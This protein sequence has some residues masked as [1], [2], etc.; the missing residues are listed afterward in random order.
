MLD[1][2]VVIYCICDEVAKS[3]NLVDDSQCKM[4][5]AEIMCFA[6]LS[7]TMF[8]CD[9]KRTRLLVRHYN[10][11][12]MLLSHSRVVR[13]IHLVPEAAWL[14]AFSALRLFVRDP[15]K[16]VFI[17]DSFP[18]K[19]YENHKSF[20]ARIFVGKEF[21]G[22]SASRKQYFFGIKV[23]MVVDQD[24]VPI[25]VSFHPGSVADITALKGLPL[26]LPPGSIL[27]GDRAYTNYDFEDDLLEFEGIR[28]VAKR[29]RNLRRQHPPESD[30]LLNMRRNRVESTFSGITSRMP[31]HIKVRTERGFLLKVLL[32]ILAYMLNLLCPL[33]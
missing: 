8:N 7:S 30:F 9:Y 14:L 32:F 24:G 6:M 29:R 28:L 15:R 17:V 21:H 10:Y 33:A 5:T 31:R 25:E 26:E 27:F 18:V 2:S 20:R 13:R 4:T 11:F 19:A 23:H 16:T 22:Y 1:Q 3:L 12:S